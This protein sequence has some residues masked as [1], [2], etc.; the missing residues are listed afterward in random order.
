MDTEREIIEG[1]KDRDKNAMRIIFNLYHRSLCY[2]ANQ[3]THNRERS[4][5]IVADAFLK[6]W[7][8]NN[9]FDAL[10]GIKLFLF[11]MV[12]NGCSNYWRPRAGN[13]AN[14]EIGKLS[15]VDEN[16][17]E[18]KMIKAGVLQI[19]LEEIDKL[20]PLRQKI[21]QMSFLDE[22][23]IFEIAE[24][25]QVTVDTVRVHKAKALHTICSVMIEKQV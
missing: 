16:F 23:S 11:M 18:N 14:K 9:D 19:F 2:F 22:L 21:F 20:S 8:T 7:Q 4:E 17:I 12:R 15:E 13:E 1:L 24:K 10:T 3:A 6:L 25:L 5:E